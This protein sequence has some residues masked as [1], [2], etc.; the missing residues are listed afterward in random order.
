MFGSEHRFAE[1]GGASGETQHVG[2]IEVTGDLTG[3]S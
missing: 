2:V 3:C 1:N